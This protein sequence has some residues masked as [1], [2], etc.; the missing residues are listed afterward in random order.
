VTSKVSFIAENPHL[1][2]SNDRESRL[3]IHRKYSRCAVT[4]FWNFCAMGSGKFKRSS[5][6][7]QTGQPKGWWTSQTGVPGTGGEKVKF[8]KIS[9][10][11]VTYFQCGQ[12][13]IM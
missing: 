13:K 10:Y 2:E 5:V 4:D 12:S 1:I 6:A 3:I 8:A 11:R 9:R 7:S